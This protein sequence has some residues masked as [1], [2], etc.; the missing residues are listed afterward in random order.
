MSDICTRV[1]ETDLIVLSAQQPGDDE[2]LWNAHPN[3][4][5]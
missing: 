5:F 4:T 3:A 1:F 2:D